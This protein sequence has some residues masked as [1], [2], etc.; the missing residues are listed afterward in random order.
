V[1]LVVEHLPKQ[2]WGPEVK[3]Q[4]CWKKWIIYQVN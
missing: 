2:A 3:S 4:N 1:T